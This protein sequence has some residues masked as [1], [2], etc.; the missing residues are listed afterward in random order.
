MLT[1]IRCDAFRVNGKDGEVRPPIKFHEGLNTVLGGK[2]ADNSIGKSTFL[3]IIDFC[4]GGD[5]YAKMDVKNYV[6]D[7]TI[8]FAFRF[9]DGMHYFSRTVSTPNVVNICN[10]KYEPQSSMKIAEYR[11]WLLKAYKID[12]PDAS[13]RDLV[14]R[15]FRV[16]GKGNDTNEKPLHNGSPSAADA[17]T[18][19]EKLF[20]LYKFVDELKRKLKE[21]KD[22]KE[23]YSKARRL[24]LVPNAITSQKRYDENEARIAELEQERDSLTQ[25][26][27]QELLQKELARK[28]QAAQ[29]EVQLRGMERQYKSLSSRYRVV[30]KNRDEQFIATEDDLQRLITFFPNANIRHIQEVEDFHR[31]LAGILNSEMDEEAESL[32]ILIRAATDEIQKLEQ[33]L[34]ELGVP[35]QIPKSF[36][37]RY[38]ELNKQISA[39]RSQNEAYTRTNELKDEVKDIEARLD[40]SEMQVLH[41]IE[42]SIN[43][44]MVR[45]NDTLYEI[46]REAP[47]IRFES[48][49]KY[50]FSTPR[51][52]GKGTAFKSL[53]VLDLSILKLTQLPF[54][55]HDSSIFKNIWDEPVDKIME[56]YLQHKKQIFIA[57]DKDQSYKD[58]TAEIV[59]NTT[60]LRLGTNGQEL[61]G[62]CWAI[63]ESDGSSN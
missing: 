42:A 36:L 28:D 62:W 41:Q 21:A 9:D 37:D 20:G 19:L 59:N 55:G 49:S 39:L 44:Q 31:E 54:I 34:V 30:T 3:L 13:F 15:F 38:S 60:V 17:I 7:H 12:L 52:D 58:R 10:E 48:K 25:E 53:I 35:L 63:K 8:C 40:E 26:T 50:E 1:E 4:F 32:Q 43:A 27:D 45:Y 24:Q 29:V 18:S 56:L 33:Q 47:T 46:P 2:D 57:F 23:T 51:D 61:F 14:S 22:K 16:S 11:A 6:G 5:T